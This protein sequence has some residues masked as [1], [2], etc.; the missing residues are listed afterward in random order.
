MGPPPQAVLEWLPEGQWASL[1]ALAEISTSSTQPDVGPALPFRQ[2]LDECV[3]TLRWRVWAE[4]AAPESERLPGDWRQLKLF[5]KLLVV[6]CLRP[7]RIVHALRMFIVEVMGRYMF[8]DFAIPLE[9]VLAETPVVSPILFVLSS[10]SDPT[11]DIDAAL[12]RVNEQ[13]IHSME[14]ARGLSLNGGSLPSLF[15][16]SS[17]SATNSNV[18]F[19]ADNHIKAVHISMG[20][21]Q[22]P[23]AEDAIWSACEKGGWVVLYNVHL[24]RKWI[25]VLDR[26]VGRFS[27]DASLKVHPDFRLLLSSEP[28]DH[29]PSTLLQASTKLVQEPPSGLRAN[30]SR[31]YAHYADEPWEQSTKPQE[32]HAIVFSMCYFHSVMVERVKFGAIGWNRRYPFNYEDLKACTDVLAGYLEDRPRVPWEDLRYVFGEVIYGGHITDQWDSRVCLTYLE[33]F[34]NP[35]TIDLANIATVGGG[36]V[37]GLGAE[38]VPGVPLPTTRSFADTLTMIQDA[39]QEE[40]PQLFLINPLSENR[41]RAADAKDMFEAL[42]DV[43][44]QSHSSDA[45]DDDVQLDRLSMLMGAVPE[46]ISLVDIIDRIGDEMTPLQHVFMQECERLNRLSDRMRR[47]LENAEAAVKGTLTM[48]PEIDELLTDIH[49]DRVP[50]AWLA[51]WGPTRRPL[52]SWTA[53]VGEANT[54]LSNWALDLLV[55]RAV[56]I[57]CL[58]IPIAFLTALQQEAALR[59][60]SELNFMELVVEVTKRTVGQIDLHARD[61]CFVYGFSMEGASWDTATNCLQEARVKEGMLMPVMVIRAA[62]IGKIDRSDN[63]AC[64]VYSTTARA[65]TYVTSLFLK[66]RVPASTWV[67][68]GTALILDGGY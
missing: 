62:H 16:V 55:P 10:G 40:S 13:R 59:T 11:N 5:D 4:L 63:Y 47:M 39:L 24:M 61:G 1:N 49:L 30:M 56:N 64:P 6:R 2:L 22:E 42:L 14:R 18:N 43:L 12:T 53:I 60:N 7:D 52:A 58:F 19:V 29:I 45:L 57:S 36:N 17:T 20:Q 23:G 25:Y 67:L 9:E 41:A 35:E 26:I 48:S 37:G 50:A 8:D 66:T 21:G 31:A 32:Y 44:P 34:I 68:R 65:T 28:V 15:G 54:Q 46:A 33:Q 38:I 51:I 27:Q 3:D